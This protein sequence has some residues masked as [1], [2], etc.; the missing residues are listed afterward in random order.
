MK[1]SIPVIVPQSSMSFDRFCPQQ[2][3]LGLTAASSP[4]R[5]SL[6]RELEPCYQQNS[7]CRR[8]TATKPKANLTINMEE[9]RRG[10]MNSFEVGIN[11]V[12]HDKLNGGSDKTTMEKPLS[13]TKHACRSI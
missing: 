4:D 11:S 7:C 2:C 10:Y 6:C 1:L 9:T 3:E 12:E 5:G 8:A 13:T